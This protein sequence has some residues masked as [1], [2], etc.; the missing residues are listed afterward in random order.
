MTIDI[1]THCILCRQPMPQW[2]LGSDYCSSRCWEAHHGAE[3][4]ADDSDERE[5][6]DLE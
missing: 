4:D 1:P 3:T 6:E 5:P 2:R